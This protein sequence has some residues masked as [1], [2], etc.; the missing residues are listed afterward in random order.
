MNINQ[1]PKTGLIRAKAIMELLG[2]K[3]GWQWAQTKEKFPLPKPYM[4]VANSFIYKVEDI[5]EYLVK[6]K[7]N[8]IKEILISKE[9]SSHKG[10]TL[11]WR[12]IIADLIEK[13][14]EITSL[15]VMKIYQEKF[16]DDK[17]C[18]NAQR[19]GVFKLLNRLGRQNIIKMKGYEKGRIKIWIAK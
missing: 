4:K 14:E 18:C 2:I 8:P 13:E 16:L 1:L 15:K 3:T 9:N 12:K 7:E 5:K 17:S 10:Y 19:A 11:L 6:F